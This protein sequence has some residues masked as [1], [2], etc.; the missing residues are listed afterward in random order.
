MLDRSNTGISDNELE[1]LLSQQRFGV[2]GNDHLALYDCPNITNKCIDLISRM[3][4][5]TYLCLGRT[6]VDGNGIARLPVFAELVAVNFDGLTNL[7]SAIP[8]ILSQPKLRS[9][10][11]ANSDLTLSD[12]ETL[13]RKT[14]IT[15]FDISG[16]RI[17]WTDVAAWDETEPKIDQRLVHFVL[18]DAPRE[19]EAIYISAR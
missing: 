1:L 18:R 6:K 19:G 10:E 7:A 13:V 14:S 15:G 2:E 12:L 3:P 11:A 8:S 16:C 17:N 5:L 9:L 4:N